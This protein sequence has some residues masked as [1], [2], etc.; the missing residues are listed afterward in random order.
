MAFDLKKP[1]ATHRK[2]QVF[3]DEHAEIFGRPLV[4]AHRIVL[5]QLFLHQIDAAIQKL[6]N[7]LFAKYALT[8]FF[9]LYVLRLIFEDG[10]LGETVLQRPQEFTID[11][12]KR[13]ALLVYR[14]NIE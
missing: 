9:M 4:T 14:G 6:N 3:E 7:S 8:R 2:Y 1:W 13:R 10:D 12:K 11:L 5:C